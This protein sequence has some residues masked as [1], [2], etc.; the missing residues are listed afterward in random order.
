MNGWKVLAAAA[1]VVMVLGAN[2][3]AGMINWSAEWTDSSPLNLDNCE[4]DLVGETLLITEDYVAAAVDSY[5]LQCSGEAST[6]PVIHVVKTVTNNSTFVWTDYHVEITGSQGVYYDPNSAT[7]DVFG[8][9]VENGWQI[10][11]YAPNSVPIGND[12]TLEFDIVVPEGEFTFDID[13]TPTPE[14][15][16]LTVLGLGTVVLLKFRR[17]WSGSAGR[18]HEA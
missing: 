18:G 2:A 10:D 15:V 3:Q 9:I 11:F 16:T 5:S 13:Q 14:P 4:V 6:D 1:I 7:S 12:V 17:R 8:T